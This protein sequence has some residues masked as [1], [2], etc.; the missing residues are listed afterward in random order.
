MVVI[1]FSAEFICAIILLILLIIGNVAAALGTIM[2]VLSWIIAIGYGIVVLVHIIATLDSGTAIISGLSYIARSV[3]IILLSKHLIAE[4]GVWKEPTGII[5][6]IFSGIG[7][8][9]LGC[10]FFGISLGAMTLSSYLHELSRDSIGGVIFSCVLS[11]AL[12]IFIF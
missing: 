10:L 4:L 7:F 8:I 6:S 2:S 5:S 3:P 12:F 1:F 11:I 9:L